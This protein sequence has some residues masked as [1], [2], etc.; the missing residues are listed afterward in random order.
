MW[1]SYQKPDINGKRTE[2]ERNSKWEKEPCQ[3][4]DYGADI[5]ECY[6]K[7]FHVMNMW[8]MTANLSVKLIAVHC[9]KTSDTCSQSRLDFQGVLEG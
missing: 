4:W 5:I 9:F 3:W 1:N 7:D 8:I 2:V 6:Q